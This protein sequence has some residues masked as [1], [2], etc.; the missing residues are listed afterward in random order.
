MANNLEN[1]DAYIIIGVKDKTFEV[2]GLASDKKRKNTQNL[3][4]Y[5]KDMDFVGGIRPIVKVQTIRINDKDIDVIIIKN[6][7]N[8]PYYLKNSHDGVIANHIYTRI[9]DTNT[10]KKESADID[11][12]EYLW[13][14]RFGLMQPP[15]EK[16]KIYMRDNSNWVNGPYGEFEKYYKYFPEY[17]MKYEHDETRDAY[18]YYFSFQTN[19]NF[20]YQRIDFYYHQTLLYET[21][22]VILD[23]GRYMTPCP[24]TDGVSI[25]R[26]MDWDIT[27]CYLEKDSIDY[28]INEFL[29]NSEYDSSAEF[30]RNQFLKSILVFENKDEREAFKDYILLN[31]EGSKTRYYRNIYE[32]NTPEL[33]S[34]YKKDAF[35]DECI[36]I[37]ILQY[38]L[39]DFKKINTL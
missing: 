9:Q 5:L 12:V 3:V 18:Q 27:Y 38:M 8:T 17:T 13:K 30:A 37:Q 34:K 16:L 36:N 35:K 20:D 39:S 1:H 26:S 31:W 33:N 29:Y 11:K 7:T 22:G 21:V 24:Y 10:P 19:Q 23:G 32:V 28:L 14:K 4:D 6:T 2:L 15:I 25:T